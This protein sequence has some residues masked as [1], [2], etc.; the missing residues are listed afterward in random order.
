VKIYKRIECN[1]YML[2]AKVFLNDEL[3]FSTTNSYNV[4]RG[5]NFVC[6]ETLVYLTQTKPFKN[7]FHFEKLAL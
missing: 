3:I 5:I 2:D 4:E 7:H 1:G 6:Y